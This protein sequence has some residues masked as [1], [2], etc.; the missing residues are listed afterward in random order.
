MKIYNETGV[1]IKKFAEVVAW[2][3][4]TLSFLVG[5]IPLLIVASASQ[6]GRIPA[7]DWFVFI[8]IGGIVLGIVGAFLCWLQHLLF[9]GF[10]ELIE[11]NAKSAA[12]LKEIKELLREMKG[13]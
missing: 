5:A 11:E 6:P 8:V 7:P 9:A 13:K 12:E 1:K 3:G 2:V 10:G 4:M